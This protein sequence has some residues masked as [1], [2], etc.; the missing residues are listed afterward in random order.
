M[1]RFECALARAAHLQALACV[2]YIQKN[3]YECKCFYV[4]L[5]VYIYIYMMS[6]MPTR[7]HRA[8]E[9]ER[10]RESKEIFEETELQ[11]V[12]EEMESQMTQC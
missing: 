2:Y 3:I 12:R 1:P 5:C 7:G 4:I 10:E 9:E 11:A 6:T 8:P